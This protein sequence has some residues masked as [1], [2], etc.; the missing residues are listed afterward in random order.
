MFLALSQN[1]NPKPKSI[2]SK[3]KLCPKPI[4]KLAKPYQNHIKPYQNQIKTGKLY[5]NPYQYHKTISKPIPQNQEFSIWC[6]PIFEFWQV[7][8]KY[9]TTHFGH[10]LL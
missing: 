2:P 10:G 9:A 3:P 7:L 1:P 8:L 4:P 5:Q 6:I